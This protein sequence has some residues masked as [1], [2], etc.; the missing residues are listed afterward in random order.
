[1]FQSD[2]LKEGH[3]QE[4]LGM[5]GRIILEWLLKEQLGMA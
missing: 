2:T 5:C 1:M 4:D 3:H